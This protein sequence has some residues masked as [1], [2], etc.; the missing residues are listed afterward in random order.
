M[1]AAHRFSR[2]ELLVGRD[3][4]ARLEQASVAVAALDGVI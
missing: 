4:L 1:T 2:L 3:G